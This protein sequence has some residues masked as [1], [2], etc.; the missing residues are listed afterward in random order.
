MKGVTNE[1]S[2]E[3]G[4]RSVVLI[5]FIKV[6]QKGMSYQGHQNGSRASYKEQLT[7]F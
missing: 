6:L 2:E 1:V 3:S 4:V 7:T 5:S